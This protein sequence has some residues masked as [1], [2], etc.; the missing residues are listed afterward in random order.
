MDF[1]TD[2]SD[3][4]HNEEICVQ[5]QDTKQ[6]FTVWIFFNYI[7]FIINQ[8]DKM[9]NHFVMYSTEIFFSYLIDVKQGFRTG[10]KLEII[11]DFFH[12]IDD[13]NWR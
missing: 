4:S 8:I 11:S 13:N 1:L 10:D 9:T 5:S 7:I 12:D 6:A 2:F 3:S